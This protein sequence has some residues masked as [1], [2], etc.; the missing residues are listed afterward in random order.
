MVDRYYSYADNKFENVIPETIPDKSSG[1]L[2]SHGATRMPSVQTSPRYFEKT[3]A[4]RKSI[5]CEQ[6]D[7]SEI[8]QIRCYGQIRWY[9]FVMLQ[10][11]KC[12]GDG[13]SCCKVYVVF[14]VDLLI[15][16]FQ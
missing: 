1:G 6:R 4:I 9:V 11:K 2:V 5:P 10:T 8:C 14:L 12:C 7:W 15:Y 16:D 3:K 13:A